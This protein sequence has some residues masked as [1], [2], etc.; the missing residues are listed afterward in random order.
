MSTPNIEHAAIRALF[1]VSSGI[2]DLTHWVETAPY[3]MDTEDQAVDVGA[4][5]L[6]RLRD[7]R[8]L[9]LR[10]MAELAATAGVPSPAVVSALEAS[11][12][13][14]FGKNPRNE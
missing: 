3:L 8:A 4:E 14:A 11:L 10:H 7:T 6:R 1:E 13:G 5:I 9:A 12:E 2:S